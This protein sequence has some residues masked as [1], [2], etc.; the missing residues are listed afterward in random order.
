M[1]YC[2]RCGHMLSESDTICRFCGCAQPYFPPRPN[3]AAASGTGSILS[4][5]IIKR[6]FNIGAVP[7]II[8]SIILVM[9]VNPIGSPLAAAAGIFAVCGN[10]QESR[11][12]AK[13]QLLISFVLCIAAT[14]IDVI[15]LL[16]LTFS[17]V[18]QISAYT[19][20]DGFHTP[21]NTSIF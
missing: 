5:V 10:A 18:S 4:D 13:L 7:L 12:K 3:A 15:T 14:I 16:V 21:F 17:A 9:C 1:K 11:E 19:G 2:I 8:W 20:S 6:E